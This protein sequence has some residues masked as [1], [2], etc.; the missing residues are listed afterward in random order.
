[1]DSISTLRLRVSQGAVFLAILS[2]DLQED[3]ERIADDIEDMLANHIGLCSKKPNS[4]S[5]E[6]KIVANTTF[7]CDFVWQKTRLAIELIIEHHKKVV[8]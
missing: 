2:G 1:M 8:A 6:E 3:F 4:L 7:A 5:E